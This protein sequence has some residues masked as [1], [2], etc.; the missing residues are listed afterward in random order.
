MADNTSVLHCILHIEEKKVDDMIR[1]MS[2]LVCGKNLNGKTACGLDAAF[3]QYMLNRKTLKMMLPIGVIN[4]G[5]IQ[6]I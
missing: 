2:P 3:S 1:G 5:Y 4:K 6:V